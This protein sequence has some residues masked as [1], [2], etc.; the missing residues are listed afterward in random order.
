MVTIPV[1]SGN[2]VGD[3]TYDITLT[4]ALLDASGT[5]IVAVT[6]SFEVGPRHLGFSPALSLVGWQCCVSLPCP[7]E[8]NIGVS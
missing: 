1:T 4:A 3:T 5:A 6:L 7:R 8:P 2:L